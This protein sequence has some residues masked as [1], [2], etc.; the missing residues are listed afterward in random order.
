MFCARYWRM[1]FFL[2]IN[3]KKKNPGF[4]VCYEYGWIHRA[5]CQ[6]GIREKGF[7]AV[8]S[9]RLHEKYVEYL[10]G[11]SPST[12]PANEFPDILTLCTW[13]LQNF[14]AKRLR[15]C[16]E[17]KM[18]TAARLRPVEAQYQDEFYRAFNTVVGRGVP[19]SS[20]WS[21]GSNERVDFW[22]PEPHWGIELL[23][24]HSHVD[25]HC[26]RF[27][28]GGLYHSWVVN[29]MIRDYIVIDCSTS[30]PHNAH[31]DPK[32]IRAVFTQDYSQLEILDH[33]NNPLQQPIVLT[34]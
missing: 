7:V 33:N 6:V 17:G 23:R 2:L 31:S 27:K 4:R 14:S 1:D 3:G 24:D 12:F 20:E 18:S 28:P 19:I 32:L 13:I 8:L 25:E 22:I 15:H 21:P 26:D 10:I 16:L 9:S 29:G 11:Q 34:N 5:W 30:A